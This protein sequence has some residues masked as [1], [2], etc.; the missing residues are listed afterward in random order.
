MS[1][2]TEEEFRYLELLVRCWEREGYLTSFE[3]ES[4]EKYYALTEKALR[5]SKEELH[6]VIKDDLN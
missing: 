3:G 5:A 4:G 2:L 1:K 6:S